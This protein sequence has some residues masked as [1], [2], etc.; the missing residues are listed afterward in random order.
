M[1]FNFFLFQPKLS[2]LEKQP[3]DQEKLSKKPDFVAKL[4]IDSYGKLPLFMFLNLIFISCL[5]HKNSSK[6]IS[7]TDVPKLIPFHMTLTIIL[8]YLVYYTFVK[9]ERCRTL[10]QSTL[11]VLGGLTLLYSNSKLAANITLVVYKDLFFDNKE[12]INFC[13][14]YQSFAEQNLY[15]FGGMFTGTCIFVIILDKQFYCLLY[16]L[17]SKAD[18]KYKQKFFFIVARFYT[19]FVVFNF[20]ITFV[21][22]IVFDVFDDAIICDENSSAKID[23]RLPKIFILLSSFLITFI[24]YFYNNL[25]EMR[26]IEDRLKK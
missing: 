4:F 20:A 23:H 16:K 2:D 26:L 7:S 10:L 6:N 11:C 15:R 25:Y 22:Y 14:T 19:F 5:D 17:E 1:I 13:G 21:T 12:S 18:W 9:F 24:I 8:L 3:N